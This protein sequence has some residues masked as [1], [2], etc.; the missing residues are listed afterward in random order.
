VTPA[1]SPLA[2]AL[3]RFPCYCGCKALTWVE[4]PADGYLE[5]KKGVPIQQALPTL[6]DTDRETL[7]TGMCPPCQV[8]TFVEDL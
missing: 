4:A 8:S 7:L 5:W 6:S 1:E 2:R 3:L